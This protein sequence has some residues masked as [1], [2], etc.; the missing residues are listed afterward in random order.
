MGGH[1]GIHALLYGFLKRIKLNFLQPVKIS[2]DDRQQ[3]VRILVSIAMAGEMFG[4]SYHPVWLATLDKSS[5]Q[6]S[7]QFRVFT[8]RP[9]IYDRIIRVD[10]NINHR[11]ISHMNPESPALDSGNTAHLI[12][13][14]FWASRTQSHERREESRSS[15][16]VT[17]SSFQIRGN[18][19]RNFSQALKMVGKVSSLQRLPA[20]KDQSTQM[21][22]MDKL[23]QL[24][25]IFILSIIEFPVIADNYKLPDFF[26]Q[27]HFFHG[28][29]DPFLLIGQPAR[30]LHW[31]NRSQTASHK[32]Y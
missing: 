32:Y 17:G 16:L 26:L 7:H 18:K 24:L 19:K 23:L 4:R 11:G 29:F 27:A 5:G 30:F 3:T 1:D 2:L 8:D 13:Q 20:K 21:I 14:F 12:S 9:G 15:H 22:V 28:L 6:A 10:I 25:K 31:F